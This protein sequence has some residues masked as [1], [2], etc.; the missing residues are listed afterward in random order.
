MA[1]T[2]K[3][4]KQRY[5]DKVYQ[6]APEILCACGCGTIIK[7]KDK[8]GRDKKYQ[9]GHNARKYDEPRNYKRE[10]SQRKRAELTKTKALLIEQKGG[11]CKICGYK[12]DGRNHAAFDFHHRD[13]DDKSFNISKTTRSEPGRQRLLKEVEKCDL[14]C[15]I[16]HRLTHSGYFD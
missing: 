11:E 5:F 4:I 3:Q 12:F 13:A 6:Q 9:N 1:L 15:A 14:L 2:N 8:Y 7:N 10:F 16:C